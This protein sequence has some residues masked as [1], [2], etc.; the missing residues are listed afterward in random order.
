M[1]ATTKRTRCS[2]CLLTGHNARTCPA[3]DP[4]DASARPAFV[5]TPDQVDAVA[6]AWT[7]RGAR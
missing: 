4:D 2:L 3:L 5:A 1:E 7:R 6:D